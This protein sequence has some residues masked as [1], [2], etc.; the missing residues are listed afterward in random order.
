MCFN[1][2]GSSKN[3]MN[4][5]KDLSALCNRPSLEAKGNAKGNLTRPHASYC[6]RPT[7]RNDILKWLKKLQFPDRYS[8]NMKQAVNIIADKLNRPKSQDYHIII[9]RLMSVIFH[10][11]FNAYLWKIFT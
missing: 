9:G 1:V 11:Y 7:E 6:L 8:S 10:D 3:N 5:R 2:T 4:E